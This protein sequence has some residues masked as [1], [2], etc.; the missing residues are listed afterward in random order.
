MGT[1]IEVFHALNLKNIQI[2]PSYIVWEIH[3]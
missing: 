2:L 3:R 1:G